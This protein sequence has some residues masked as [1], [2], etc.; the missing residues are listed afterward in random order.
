MKGDDF[1]NRAIVILLGVMEIILIIGA[2][3]LLFQEK[4]I[5]EGITMMIASIPSGLLGF[6]KNTSN[7]TTIQDSGPTTVEGDK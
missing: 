1:T 3:A 5:P 7:Q 6:L 4:Q 2:L